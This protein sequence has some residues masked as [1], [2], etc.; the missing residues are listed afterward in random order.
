M[1][2]TAIRS[3]NPAS[4][5]CFPVLLPWREMIANSHRVWNPMEIPR[6][7]GDDAFVVWRNVSRL[8]RTGE[9]GNYPTLAAALGGIHAVC[10]KVEFACVPCTLEKRGAA[11]I[12]HWP[13]H[14]DR[15]FRHATL[16]NG[17]SKKI[18]PRC[19]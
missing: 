17:S 5:F 12:A 15:T 11:P 9:A 7:F 4:V 18:V 13:R 1:K 8:Y 14:I 10:E 3:A 19:G 16:V 2:M 6:H